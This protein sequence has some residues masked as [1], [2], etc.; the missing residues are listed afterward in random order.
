MCKD[1]RV[2][3]HLK[4][5]TGESLQSSTLTGNELRLD[6]CTRGFWQK[7][8]IVFFDVSAFNPSVKIYVNKESQKYTNLKKKLMKKK[9]KSYTMSES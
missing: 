6:I 9:R 4:Q 8:Q 7:V 5:P 1:I 2:E 3:P